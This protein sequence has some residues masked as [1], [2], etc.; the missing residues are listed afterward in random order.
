MESRAAFRGTEISKWLMALLAL[1]V[2][3][4]LSVMA[5]YMAKSVS[6]PAATQTNS[7]TTE[8]GPTSTEPAYS[9]DPSG[10]GLIP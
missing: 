9:F 10:Y 3:L 8:A 4:G 7:V 5:G 6:A 2:A 1:I